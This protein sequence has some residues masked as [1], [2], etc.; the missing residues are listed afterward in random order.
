MKACASC[1]GEKTVGEFGANRSRRDGLNAYCRPCA[2][3]KGRDAMA[4][5]LAKDPGYN[6]RRNAETRSDPERRAQERA[7][8][9]DAYLADPSIRER[10]RVYHKANWRK[11]HKVETAAACKARHRARLL[12]A[13]PSWADQKTITSFYAEARRASL[14]TGVVHHVDHIVPLKGKTVCGLHVPW[15][16][17]VLTAFANQ[18]K[19]NR[20]IA[21]HGG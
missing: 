2:R 10:K 17:Q 19:G 15:N 21:V 13:T 14:K 12:S 3:A 20:L 16:L 1:M 6:A 5:L 4:R 11:Y 7:R 18:S 8:N 9:R